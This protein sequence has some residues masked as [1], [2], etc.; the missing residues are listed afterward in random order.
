MRH[1]AR[2][3]PAFGRSILVDSIE[4]RYDEIAKINKRKEQ[5]EMEIKA[6]ESELYL[7]QINPYWPQDEIKAAKE[8]GNQ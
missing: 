1:W 8:K 3:L 5:L 7:E 4:N 6:F 2:N